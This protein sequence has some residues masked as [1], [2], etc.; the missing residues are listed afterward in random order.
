[1]AAAAGL[2]LLSKEE[3]NPLHTTTYGVGELIRECDS[4]RAAGILLSGSA[5]VRQ[6]T[7]E[8]GCFRRLDLNFW[9]KVVS[10]CETGRPG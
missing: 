1:M 4:E 3:R 10:R 5:A 9:I 7:A 2:P 8:L 6:T